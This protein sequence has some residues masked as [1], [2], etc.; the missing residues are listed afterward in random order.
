MATLPP[1][2]NISHT[3]LEDTPDLV[4]E[5]INLARKIATRNMLNVSVTMSPDYLSVM[6]SK[7]EEQ[8]ESEI[9][10]KEIQ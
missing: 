8:K 2:D 9:I 6:I 7:Q 10:W 1:I 4:G 3:E 5:L